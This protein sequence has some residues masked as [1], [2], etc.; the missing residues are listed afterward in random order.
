VRPP[1]DPGALGA[2]K[3]ESYKCYPDRNYKRQSI[4]HFI[5]EAG[6]LPGIEQKDECRK[7]FTTYEQ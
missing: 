6:C 1:N 5:Y 3:I 4:C 7:G 2:V